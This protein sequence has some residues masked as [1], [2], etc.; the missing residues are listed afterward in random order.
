[1]PIPDGHYHHIRWQRLPDTPVIRSRSP[2][3]LRPPL[4]LDVAEHGNVLDRQV[5]E[6]IQDNEEQR[7]FS[8]VD[9]ATLLV[10]ELAFLEISGRDLLERLGIDIVDEQQQKEPVSPYYALSI[11]FET[12]DHLGSFIEQVDRSSMDILFIQRQRTSG[13]SVDPNRLE[14]CFAERDAAVQFMSTEHQAQFRFMTE[15]GP[16]RKSSRTLHKLLVQFKDQEAMSRFKEELSSYKASGSE[17]RSLTANQRRE[18]FDS[19]T[20]VKNLGPSDRRGSRLGSHE[21]TNADGYHYFDVDLWHP[22]RNLIAQAIRQFREVVQGAGG[23][24]TDSP[25]SVAD[26]LLLAR[27][28]GTI[29]TLEA[30]L[31]YDRVALVDLPPQEPIPEFSIFDPIELPLDAPVLPDDGPLACVVDSG[32]VAGHPLLSGLV[33]DERDFD[34]GESTPVDKV[35]HGTH[36]AGIVVYGDTVDCL[37]RSSWVPRVRLLSAKV[38]RRLDND[39]VGFGDEKRVETQV[40]EAITAFAGE[41]SFCRVF[42]ISFGHQFRQYRGGRQLPWAQLLDE[43]A[44][45]LNIVIVVSIGNVASPDV[46]KARTSASFRVAVRE[47]LLTDEHALIDPATAA[48]ALT[49][50]SIARMETPSQTTFAPEHRPPLV[51]SPAGC[52]SPFTRTGTLRK[53]GMGVSR[54]IKPELTTFGGNYSLFPGMNWTKQDP[55]LGEPSLRFDYQG[56]RLLSVKCGTSV[57]AAHVTHCC[58]VIADELRR[59]HP[60]GVPVSANLIRCLAVHSARA[61]ECATRWM[62]DGHRGAEA[63]KRILKTIGFGQPDIIRAAFSTEQRATLIAEDE[64]ELDRLHLYEIEIPNEFVSGSGRRLVRVTLAYDPPTR[65]TR[66]DYLANT[67]WFRIYRGLNA[68]GIRNAVSRGRAGS[69]PTI[70]RS[71]VV[72]ARPPYTSLEW[73]TVQCAVFEGQSHRPFSHRTDPSAP[74]IWHLLVGCNSRFASNEPRDQRYAIAVSLEHSNAGIRLYQV[75]RQRVEQRIRIYR[76]Y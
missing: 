35:G 34:S 59:A 71:C 30:L 46:P 74:V 55:A 51:G 69:E 66:K 75:V 36:I 15:R 68:D 44:R 49:V 2:G 47:R 11:R 45:K 52:P 43:L 22:G 58:A 41:Y 21:L 60:R 48:L 67:M 14:V 57:S 18:L 26:T 72:R 23:R 70:P 64:I 5:Q 17:R 8:G 31:H 20:G 39:Q 50:G 42:N 61:G 16:S 1:M 12:L 38:M 27:V 9:P 24:V 29:Q 10:L 19:M 53:S 28:H 73:S 13:G 54:G 7:R 33:V 65:G 62:G 32:V 56:T 25:T 40:R 3:N 76:P 37:R 6:A 63:E 4:R